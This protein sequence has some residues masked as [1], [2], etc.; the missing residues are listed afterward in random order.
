MNTQCN[1]AGTGPPAS[2]HISFEAGVLLFCS[3]TILWHNDKEPM[4]WEKRNGR[5][6]YYRKERRG[7]TVRSVYVG[8]G[9]YAEAVADLNAVGRMK[10][11]HRRA[12]WRQTKARHKRTERAVLDAERG[13]R[14]L[15]DAALI[16]S[17]YHTHKGTWRK[18]RSFNKD[19]VDAMAHDLMNQTGSR[20]KKKEPPNPEVNFSEIDVPAS[21]AALIRE[22]K[23]AKEDPDPETRAAFRAALKECPEVLDELGDVARHARDVAVKA[24]FSGTGAREAIRAKMDALREELASERAAR[25]DVPA[26]ERLLIENVVIAW[27]HFHATQIKYQRV[28]YDSHPMKRGRYWEKRLDAAQRRFLRALRS[29]AN[30]RKMNVTVQINAAKH[31]QIANL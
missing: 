18:S 24:H 16:A 22:T 10:R 27:L 20:A 23:D 3:T 15:R 2:E 12:E 11:A 26:T 14:A 6:Y 7:D 4:G 13:I 1:H 28:T 17:G 25:G 29:L 21:L 9:A 19:E 31:Q 30:V 5:R 8:T